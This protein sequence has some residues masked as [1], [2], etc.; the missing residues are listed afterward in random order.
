MQ[1]VMNSKINYVGQA[2]LMLLALLSLGL[3]LPLAPKS[4]KALDEEH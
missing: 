4:T 3:V 1:K 2:S